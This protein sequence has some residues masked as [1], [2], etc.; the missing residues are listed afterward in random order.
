MK[1]DLYLSPLGGEPTSTSVYH[2]TCIN[3]KFA[4]NS[5]TDAVDRGPCIKR[6]LFTSDLE[7]DSKG[8]QGHDIAFVIDRGIQ[9]HVIPVVIDRKMS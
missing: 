2:A 1:L 8:F 7:E 6:F 4:F 3:P 9:C 5:Y